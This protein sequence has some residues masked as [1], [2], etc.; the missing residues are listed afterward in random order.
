M[1]QTLATDTSHYTYVASFVKLDEIK[2][3]I[4]IN[5]ILNEHVKTIPKPIPGKKKIHKVYHHMLWINIRKVI[6]VLRTKL[7]S[8]SLKDWMN[9]IG[10]FIC[11]L[12][13]DIVIYLMNIV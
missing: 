3:L 2:N 9:S 1:L 11:Q 13:N 6:N 4:L 7:G 10:P 8:Q 12:S 5:G